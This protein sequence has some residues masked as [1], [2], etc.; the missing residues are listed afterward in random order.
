MIAALIPLIT[1]VLD[2]VLPDAQ[3]S[4]DAKLK[5]LE[6]AQK[7]ELAVL[8]ADLKISLAQ[9]D[10]NK[11]EA[12]TDTF[13]GGWRPFIGWVAGMGLTYDFLIRPILPWMLV[14][15]GAVDTIAPMPPIDMESLM[16]LLLGMLGLG[17]LRT[18]EKVKK[19][20]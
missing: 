13:R 16:V 10:I 7:G 17:G 3:A 20:A 2:K 4:S 19:V 11:Q 14:A 6:L 5:V 1:G 18:Y 15:T 8:D 12:G 9:A